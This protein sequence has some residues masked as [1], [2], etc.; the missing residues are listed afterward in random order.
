MAETKI[1]LDQHDQPS[2]KGVTVSP[3]LQRLREIAMSP[4]MTTKIPYTDPND[5]RDFCPCGVEIPPGPDTCSPECEAKY[6]P[7]IPREPVT[8]V[9]PH[10]HTLDCA[11]K[12]TEKTPS[13]AETMA[14]D[15]AAKGQKRLT[16]TQFRALRRAYFTVRHP[17]VRECGHKVDQINQPKN[18]CEY[19]WF[20]FFSSHGELV[21]TADRAFQEQG[22]G[23]LDSMRG[24]KFRKYFLRYMSTMAKFQREADEIK[25]RDEMLAALE[26]EQNGNKRREAGSES[27]EAEGGSIVRSTDD[28]GTEDGGDQISGR[29]VGQAVR[30]EG[31]VSTPGQDG[32]ATTTVDTQ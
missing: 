5:A 7:A 4:E 2:E 15:V 19:C 23:F 16:E 30:N 3:T 29:V 32:G 1:E 25:R 13:V 31:D 26:Q 22:S 11:G 17:H 18:N 28:Q 10:E 12:C 21:Q 24:V 9:A 27:G 8:V 6:Y 20:A 14:A